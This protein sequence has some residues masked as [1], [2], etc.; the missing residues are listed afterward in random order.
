M[1]VQREEQGRNE[2]NLDRPKMADKSERRTN[3][4][5]K[6]MGGL[7]GWFETFPG[8]KPTV[9]VHFRKKEH[10]VC[11][12]LLLPFRGALYFSRYFPSPELEIQR[13]Y[14]NILSLLRYRVSER[15]NKKGNW[16]VGETTDI[17]ILFQGYDYDVH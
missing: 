13:K 15:N 6:M 10:A 14:L 5:V 1:S 7:V 16:R 11:A 8:E 3:V 17:V 9:V 12:V 2:R 4:D